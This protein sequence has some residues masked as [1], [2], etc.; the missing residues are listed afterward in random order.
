[1][2]ADA[3]AVDDAV[4][5]LGALGFTQDATVQDE[6]HRV[7]EPLGRRAALEEFLERRLLPFL[8]DLRDT[9]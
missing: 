4:E 8:V 1:M 9:L 5:L 3:D 7:K 2:H 6:G